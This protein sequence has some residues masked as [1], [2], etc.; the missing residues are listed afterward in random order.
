MEGIGAL[1]E[2]RVV[3]PWQFAHARSIQNHARGR[4]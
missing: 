4:Q 2:L 3:T 1:I